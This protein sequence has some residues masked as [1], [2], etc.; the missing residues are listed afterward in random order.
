MQYK[1][2]NVITYCPSNQNFVQAVGIFGPRI[3]CKLLMV[4]NGTRLGLSAMSVCAEQIF[5][6]SEQASLSYGF[7]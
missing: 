4:V 7:H 5:P 1:D 3:I 2:I 6:P